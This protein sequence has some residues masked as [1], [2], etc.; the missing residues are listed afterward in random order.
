MAP[1]HASRRRQRGNVLVLAALQDESASAA[2]YDKTDGGIKALVGGLTAIVNAAF[3]VK[4]ERSPEPVGVVSPEEVYKGVEEDFTLNGYLWTGVITD[5][6]YHPDCE[7]TDP[8]LSFS[9]LATF[10]RNLA[11]LQP[12]LKCVREQRTLLLMLPARPLPRLTDNRRTTVPAAYPPPERQRRAPLAR[13][14]IPYRRSLAVTAAR[15]CCFF[16]VLAGGSC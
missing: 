1:V 3:G 8:T 11:N 2:A 13:P 4:K 15:C 16:F 9:G 10:K 12:I 7:F 6:V 5:N 14:S